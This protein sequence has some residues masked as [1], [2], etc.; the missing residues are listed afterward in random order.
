MEQQRNPL[1]ALLELSHQAR[2]A[3]SLP[4]L[5]FL[6]V[7]DSHQLVPYR[8]AALWRVEG[9]IQCLSG[10]LNVEANVPYVQW[11]NSACQ[12]LASHHPHTQRITANDL[13]EA[14]ASDYAHW[15]PA[16]A[17]WLPLT[18]EIS[19]KTV[20]YGGLLFA[21]ELPW[22]EQH[23]ALLNEWRDAWQH[24]WQAKQKPT[25]FW[26]F[27]RKRPL[28]WLR[29]WVWAPSLIA[30]AACL[31][32]Q[33]GVLAPGELVPAQP[34][35]IRAPLEGVIERFYVRPNQMVRAGQPLF[36]FDQALLQSRLDVTRQ[37]LTTAEAEYRQSA[38]QA[39]LD[40]RAKAQLAVL[41]GKI[42]ERRAELNFLIEQVTRA[43]VVA[44]QDGIA[45]FDDPTEWI[46]KPVNVGERILR[47]ATPE[48]VEVEAWVPLADAIPLKEGARISLY[49]NADPLAPVQASLRYM[50][51]DATQR[52]DG[53][54]AYRVRARLEQPTTHRIGQKGT[55]RLRGE[56]VSLGYWVMRRPLA[57]IRTLLGW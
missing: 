22:N 57:S 47:V 41:N 46:G 23:L 54:Y 31:P 39:L 28:R 19:E 35:I 55:A 18:Q 13:P 10:L 14:L 38:Q 25:H 45:L 12:W 5:E 37:T 11:L 3:N 51:H 53:T 21:R 7:N 32:V 1:A 50:A 6:A 24:A 33:L 36:D 49:L 30:L 48:A 29:P 56:W 9:G 17:L 16:N 8:Q 52:P 27:S 44:P 2:H 4:E 43:H 42:G 26:R 20:V 40:P 15:L 34:A